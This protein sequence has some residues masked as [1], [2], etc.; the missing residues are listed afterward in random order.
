MLR[1]PSTVGQHITATA[2]FITAVLTIGL[3][4][5]PAA[6]A[7]KAPSSCSRDMVTE[8]GTCAKHVPTRSLT[9][10]QKAQVAGVM[11]EQKRTLSSLNGRLGV[12]EQLN[13]PI[14]PPP[15]LQYFL[16]EVERMRLYKEGEGNGRKSYTCGPSAAR[17]MISALMKRKKGH[18]STLE[19]SYFERILGTTREGTARRNI[20]DGLNAH[21]P[22][23]GGWFTTRP[24]TANAYL[25]YVM[26]DTQRLGR[27]VI[28][29]LDTE[30][31]RRYNRKHL[32]H[33]NIVFGYD[34]RAG[35]R[36]RIGEEWDP[37]YIYGSSSYGN[38]YGKFWEP[39]DR[40]FEAIDA[41]PIHGIVA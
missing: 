13:P 9:I 14:L 21:F 25:A 40:A 31:L 17:N 33:F 3:V 12:R 41:S 7:A 34:T 35:K 24:A 19:E 5:A 29:N 11:A 22:D 4:S 30:H 37:I 2:F 38:P 8:K 27:A 20:A 15:P 39:L 32:A 1:N 28:A 23:L 18:Y 36:L 10:A 6:S 26:I 16:P